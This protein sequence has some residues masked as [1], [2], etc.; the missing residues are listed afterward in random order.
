MMRHSQMML[1]SLARI[2]DVV[3][4]QQSALEDHRARFNRGTLDE[5]YHARTESYDPNFSG[6]DSKK[7]RGVR[8]L[9]PFEVIC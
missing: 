5:E 1:E 6:G 8:I 9:R 7:R 2:R 3:I 4:Q